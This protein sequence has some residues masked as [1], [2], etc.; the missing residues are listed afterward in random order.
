MLWVATDGEDRPVGFAL[1]FEIDGYAHLDQ[2]NVLPNHTQKGLGKALLRTVCEWAR[3]RG[4][5][6][7]TLSTFR[8]VPWNGP[9]YSRHGFRVV[10]SKELTAGLAQLVERERKRGIRTDLRV[11]MRL[12]V[13]QAR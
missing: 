13:G 9:F 5:P 1:V 8:D 4:Y 10:Q 6:G 7:V 2:L 12:D 3:E 11:I